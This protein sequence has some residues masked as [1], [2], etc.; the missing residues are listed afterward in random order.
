MLTK[1]ELLNESNLSVK[2]L[3]WV[4]SFSFGSTNGQSF[5]YLAHFTSQKKF[6]LNF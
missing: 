2:I 4:A 1:E 3:K 6:I 5:L